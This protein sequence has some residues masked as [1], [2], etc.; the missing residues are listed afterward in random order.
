MRNEFNAIKNA[1][2]AT[3][4][5]KLSAYE[6]MLENLLPAQAQT[7]PP[8]V[9]TGERRRHTSGGDP[10]RGAAIEAGRQRVRAAQRQMLA[11]NPT[12]Y[13]EIVRLWR[14]GSRMR[15]IAEILNVHPFAVQEAI[16]IMNGED[17]AQ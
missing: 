13:Q 5:F 2:W 6:Q 14:L 16:K 8:V 4:E 3:T 17:S 10:E 11:R 7:S 9:V 15:P 1:S 12:V